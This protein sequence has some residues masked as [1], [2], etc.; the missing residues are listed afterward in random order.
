MSDTHF[1]RVLDLAKQKVVLRARDVH[2]I[3][4][5]QSVIQRLAAA[6]KLKKV[7]YGLYRLPGQR[8]S[9][10][11]DLEEIAVKVPQA[12]FCLLTALHFH[13]LIAYKPGQIWFAKPEGSYT[14]RIYSPPIKVVMMKDSIYTA[15]VNTINCNG[16]ELRVFNIAKTIVD[17]FRY[18]KRIGL[19]IALEALKTAQTH[20]KISAHAIGRYAAICGVA[21]VMR[22]YL[23]SVGLAPALK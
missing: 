5:P 7:G 12:V 17:C 15:G 6:G 4:S 2:A 3:G 20:N 19:D 23:E 11:K 14:P 21:P 13:G 9:K 18:H 1:Q 22:P 16:V 8:K 10:F